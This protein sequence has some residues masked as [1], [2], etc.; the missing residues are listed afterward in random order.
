MD[1]YK[2]R[3]PLSSYACSHKCWEPQ[4]Y[5]H[6]AT[7]FDDGYTI[8][9]ANGS[10]DNW[11]AYI[12]G[13]VCDDDGNIVKWMCY[14]PGDKWYFEQLYTFW[15]HPYRCYTGKNFVDTAV[16]IYQTILFVDNKS[17]NSHTISAIKTYIHSWCEPEDEDYLW[18]IFTEI[19]Y[20]MI[21]EEQK[22]NAIAGALLKVVALYDMFISGKSIEEASV[23]NCAN[24]ISARYG[25]GV[26]P[27]VV[28]LDLAKSYGLYRYNNTDLN[29]IVEK[30]AVKREQAIDAKTYQFGDA[31][32]CPT[33]DLS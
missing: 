27:V 25:E 31:S 2:K 32:D 14:A 6:D 13:P 3:Y 18:F 11:A 33:D 30:Y 10:F 20:A 26:T 1:G 23:C 9:F 8:F 12:C 19:Y 22:K 5:P 17:F 4:Y 7:R 15:K 21:A 16:F 28:I 29:Q 24:N